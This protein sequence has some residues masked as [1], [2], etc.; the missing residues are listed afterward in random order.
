MVFKDQAISQ[1]TFRA[2]AIMN[3]KSPAVHM[4]HSVGQIFGLSGLAVNVQG[5]CIGVIGLS[6]PG[7]GRGGLNSHNIFFI[8]GY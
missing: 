1:N 3:G 4:V 5:K 6:P 7:D 2:V 8:W